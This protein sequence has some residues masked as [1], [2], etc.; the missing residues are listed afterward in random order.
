[1]VHRLHTAPVIPSHHSFEVLIGYTSKE[2]DIPINSSWL[3]I[4]AGGLARHDAQFGMGWTANTDLRAG[5]TEGKSSMQ[6]NDYD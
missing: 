2:T 3:H 4:R 6:S 1:M 5:R